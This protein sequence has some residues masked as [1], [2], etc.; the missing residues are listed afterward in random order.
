MILTLYPS[1][2]PQGMESLLL[3]FAICFHATDDQMCSSE[4]IVDMTSLLLEYLFQGVSLFLPFEGNGWK[5]II[6]NY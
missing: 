6:F 5:G 1:N 3:E 2:C 4:S